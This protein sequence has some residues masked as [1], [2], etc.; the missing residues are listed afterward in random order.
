MF[1]PHYFLGRGR[2][3]S[4]MHAVVKDLQVITT[5]SDEYREYQGYQIAQWVIY[6]YISEITLVDLFAILTVSYHLHHQY[7]RISLYTI[8]PMLP[9][10]GSP[11]Y[12]RT[13]KFQHSL[14]QWNLHRFRKHG[15]FHPA[16]TLVDDVYCRTCLTNFHIVHD[17]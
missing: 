12:V 8:Y 4:Y 13:G 7:L 15:W 16:H 9:Q 3:R 17:S 1:L 5:I 11:A 2:T 10:L 14:Q 6:I